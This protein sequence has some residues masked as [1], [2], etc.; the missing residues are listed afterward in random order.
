[1]R[2]FVVG[3]NQMQYFGR[4][5]YGY[6][7]KLCN[8]FVR[9]N[10][11]I[12]RF[13]D[14]DVAR[15]ENVFRSRAFGVKGANK[16][17]L[18]QISEFQPDLVVFIHADVIQPE[19]VERLR[20]MLPAV[21]ITQISMD[22]LFVPR[23]IENVNAKSHLLDANFVTTAG[24]GLRKVS[25]GRPTYYIPNITDPSIETGHAFEE[26]CDIDLVFACGS[27]DKEGQDPRKVTLDLISQNMAQINF[28]RHVRVETGGL[29]GAEY[30]NS[31]ARSKCGLNLSRDQEG[32]HNVA[33]DEDLYVY[34]SDR[35][36]HLTGNGVLTFS[37]RKYSLDYLFSEDE[38]VFYETDQDLMDKISYYLKHDDERRRI[39]KNGWQKAH[40][41]LNERLTAEYIIDVLFRDGLS[42]SYIWPTDAII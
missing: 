36:S 15:M 38:M 22:A 27:F 7:D 4:R 26:T 17:F 25:G 9:N 31:L 1:M 11:T 23:N 33:D 39:A 2:I 20:T 40:R 14:R 42:H 3:G 8:G 16:Q 34:S 24:V 21:R 13:F 12:C 35:L 6:A 32:P 28:A 41:E 10:H 37:H 18:Q 29:W 30:M 5:Y 19:S